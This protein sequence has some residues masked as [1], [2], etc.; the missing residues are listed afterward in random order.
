MED[1]H[2]KKTYCVG[3][4]AYLIAIVVIALI[5]VVAMSLI[6]SVDF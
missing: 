3:S 2:V 5:Q 4:D 6:V 1:M